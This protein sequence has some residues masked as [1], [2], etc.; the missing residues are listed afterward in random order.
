MEKEKTRKIILAAILVLV[1][2][3]AIYQLLSS[4]QPSPQK[5][6]QVPPK[7][8]QQAEIKRP[9]QIEISPKIPSY[10][11][12]SYRDPFYPQIV[13]KEVGKGAS[14]LENY[15]LEELKLSGIIRDKNV[16][17]AL[18]R[19]PDGRHFVVKENDKIGINGGIIT[20]ISKDKLEIRETL[21]Y[22][23]GETKNITKTLKLRSE[24]GQ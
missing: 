10:D 19:T 3:Y 12:M 23:T 9:E 22:H 11:L 14:P 18:I 1:A 4:Q 7:S 21:R 8:I 15:E 6:T 20:K 5:V 16:Y 13:R 17:R 24:E 2:A